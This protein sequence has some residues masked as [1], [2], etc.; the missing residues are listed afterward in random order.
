MVL[1]FTL[2]PRVLMSVVSDSEFRMAL[3]LVQWRNAFVIHFPPRLPDIWAH[4]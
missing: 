4:L 3:A 2:F 1:Y